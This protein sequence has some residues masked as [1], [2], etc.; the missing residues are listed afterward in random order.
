MIRNVQLKHAGKY[1]CAVQTKVDSIS[2]AADLV[3]RGKPTLR[4]LLSARL[5]ATL[6]SQNGGANPCLEMIKGAL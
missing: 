5:I 6:M 2:I 4:Y 3:V 1:T